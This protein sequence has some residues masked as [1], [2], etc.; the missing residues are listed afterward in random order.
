M[1]Q[2]L[3]WECLLA[4]VVPESMS[5]ILEAPVP[6]L[7]GLQRG[8]RHKGGG[9]SGDASHA[10]AN[11][12]ADFDEVTAPPEAISRLPQWEA[13]YIALEPSYEALKESMSTVN[14]PIASGI[15]PDQIGLVTQFRSVFRD[16]MFFYTEAAFMQERVRS[17]MFA[18]GIEDKATRHFLQHFMGTQ[19]WVS[20]RDACYVAASGDARA[21][22]NLKL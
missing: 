4:P 2:P 8:A 5:Q 17:S 6:F 12:Y 7:A 3:K 9:K 10:H 13:L 16:Y 19:A 22:P 14:Q 20:Y 11:I 15:T 18:T 21:T 1:I